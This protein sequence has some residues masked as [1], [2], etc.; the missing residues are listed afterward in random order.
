MQ[1]LYTPSGN[2]LINITDGFDSTTR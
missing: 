1:S 2:I